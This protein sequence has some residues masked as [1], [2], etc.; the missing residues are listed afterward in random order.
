MEQDGQLLLTEEKSMRT[1]L[2]KYAAMLAIISALFGLQG[3]MK[4]QRAAGCANPGIFECQDDPLPPVDPEEEMRRAPAVATGR[5]SER[6]QKESDQP[7]QEDVQQF[8]PGQRTLS[9]DAG[10]PFV[11]QLNKKHRFTYCACGVC[12]HFKWGANISGL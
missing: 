3:C 7:S 5:D 8:R 2:L 6:V 9:H 1:T 11:L 10:I 4:L 12:C